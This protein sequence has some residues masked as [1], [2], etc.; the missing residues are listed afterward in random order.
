MYSP[1]LSHTQFADSAGFR[2][3][4]AGEV[5]QTMAG[6]W[7]PGGSADCSGSCPMAPGSKSAPVFRA[8]LDKASKGG[9]R[10]GVN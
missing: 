5:A 3:Q 10:R 4:R 9:G 2:A 8:M 1:V 7:H 6:H